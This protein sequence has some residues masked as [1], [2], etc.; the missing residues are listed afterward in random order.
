MA[1]AAIVEE[2]QFDRIVSRL[3]HI[4]RRG[5]LLVILAGIAATAVADWRAGDV[6]L[7]GLYIIPML[8]APMVLPSRASIVVLALTC[9][10]L[11]CTFDDSHDMLQYGLRFLTSVSSYLIA[12]LY[13]STLI[14][15]REIAL[16][17]V[18]QLTREQRLRNEAQER[19]ET[20][21]ESSPAG[22]L[23]LDQKGNIIA[24]NHAAHALFGLDDNRILEGRSIKSYMPVLMDA[25]RIGAGDEPF[26]TAAQAQGR[27]E[28]GDIF[29][30]DL[31]FST[32]DA[33][34]GTQLAAIIVDSS[35]EMRNREQQ[36]LRQLTTSSRLVAAAVLHEI[37]NL[38]GAIS[39]VYSNLAEKETPCRV[40]D[41]KGLET[42][43]KGLGR[44]ASLELYGKE[45]EVLEELS[46]QQVLDD[47]RIVVEPSWRDDNGC[48]H[49]SLP[50]APIRVL[51]ERYGLLQVFLNLAQNS[52]R[53]VQAST[54]RALTI[55][56]AVS[57][58]RATV[59]F[60][61]SGCGIEN[62]QYLFQPFQQGA[63]VTGLGLFI[64]RVIVR[65]YGGE[66]KFQPVKQGCAFVVE[67]PLVGVRH[68]N[69]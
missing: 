68:S 23:T 34:S 21:V 4:N 42:L 55:H 6:S 52:Y 14:R 17:H 35:E 60:R 64:S 38:C 19:L 56:A 16:Q 24:A 67:L 46:L 54:V 40:E 5:L 27:K 22:I 13:V 10:F 1:L 15:N 49:W 20:L 58:N 53:A 11:R 2:L 57:G 3:L 65:S 62:P 37:R 43:V 8:L 7:G 33:H 44:V 41:I 25:L 31:W 29:L 48:I 50:S 30:A 47:L 18:A 26:R 28:N 51:A 39:V 12:G 45:P 61:D 9:A 59:T 32:Y 69:V 63:D 36:N 66:L